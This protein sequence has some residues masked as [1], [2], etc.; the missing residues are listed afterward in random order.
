MSIR[1]VYV[2]ILDGALTALPFLRDAAGLKAGQSILIN[3]ASGAVGTAAVQFAKHF[4]ADVTA[5][6]STA[7]LD[8]VKSLGAD[9]TIDYKAEDFTETAES[10]DVVFDAVGKSSYTRCRKVLKPG[11]IYL[12]TVP[13]LPVLLWTLLTPLF[14]R[15]RARIVFTGLRKLPPSQR[16]CSSWGTWQHPDTTSQSSTGPTSWT[17]Q[18]PRTPTSN[19]DT[20]RAASSSP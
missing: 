4:G 6:C 10:Y 18:S 8:L 20:R 15:T 17:K 3:G 14:G 12:T 7:N 19:R 11:G 13:T 16:T 2:A 1:P 9:E 5:V